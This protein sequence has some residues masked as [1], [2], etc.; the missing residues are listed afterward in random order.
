MPSS[1][2]VNGPES[3]QTLQDEHSSS[4]ERIALGAELTHLAPLSDP[5]QP[6]GGWRDWVAWRRSHTASAIP[7]V[8]PCAK[9]QYSPASLFSVLRWTNV[10]KNPDLTQTF[11]TYYL[12]LKTDI[13]PK[14]I[15][16]ILLENKSTYCWYYANNLLWFFVEF[17]QWIHN[18]SKL[19][20]V[21]LDSKTAW[22]IT[23]FHYYI[24]DIYSVSTNC[25]R[26]GANKELL[27]KN[28]K[29]LLK[30]IIFSFRSFLA[31]SS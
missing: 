8:R 7:A 29:L 24:A 13:N 2:S 26:L 31:F 21:I 23:V 14:F 5:L 1:G 18:C 6:G 3:S 19:I 9:P 25:S 22:W 28:C 20:N 27:I 17:F 15:A 11:P 16:K 10:K 4:V 30:K 12:L